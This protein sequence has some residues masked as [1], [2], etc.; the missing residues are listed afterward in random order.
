MRPFAP[1]VALL[2]G[3][4]SLAAASGP[5]WVS[6]GSGNGP[7]VVLL[8]GDEEYRSEEALPMLARILAERHGFRCTV[9]LSHNED[10]TVNPDKGD[11]LANP[12]ALDTADALVLSLR[13]RRWNAEA[14][15]K[16]DAA[17]QRGV[18]IVALRTSTHAF[19]GIPKDSPQ[20]WYNW[21]NAGG[22]GAKVLG[23]TW[24][25]H[26]G[27]HGV[28]GTLTKA[29]AANAD[30]PV[31]RGVG[32]AFGDS[33]VYEAY[34]PAD[35]KILLRGL[36]LKGMDPKGPLS[37]KVKK[38]ARGDKGS[39]PINDPA[40]PVAWVREVPNASGKVNRVLC[41]TMGAATDLADAN[42]RR[43]VVNGVH[44]GL[45]KDVPAAANVDVVVPFKPSKF[46]FKGYRKGLTAEQFG[47]GAR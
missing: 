3:L 38:R 27:H 18:P 24:I 2:L 11:S 33:D 12:A 47:E 7:H 45:G 8:G 6:Y 16:F 23:E 41:T 9:L 4:V 30:H 25:S 32:P 10:G 40:M 14:L 36:V 21:N 39:Q 42:L 43:L 29:E 37:G 46:A 20:A 15:A 19:A 1:L 13:F 17:L 26:W 31:L 34:P 44:W 35:A 22:F 28:E 5:G